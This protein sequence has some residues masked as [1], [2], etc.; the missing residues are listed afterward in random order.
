MS[1]AVLGL[2]VGGVS[3]T[4]AEC[5]DKSFPGFWDAIS[6][7]MRMRRVV[8]FGYRG[9]GK[10]PPGRHLLARGLNVP[11]L[12]TDALIEEKSGRTIPDIFR[13]D[14]EERFRE[15]ER[16]VIGA[17]PLHDV[18]VGTGG[19]AV[20][21]PEN[22]ERLRRDSVC[23]LLA[24]DLATIRARLAK[25]PRPP[26]TSLPP[27]EEIAQVMSRRCRQY[28]AS[29]D[30]CVDTS[31]TSNREAAGP[32]L[33][34]SR[35]RHRPCPGAGGGIP[36]VCGRPSRASELQGWNPCLPAPVLMCR[37]VPRHRRLPL[38]P[39]QKPPAL[40]PAFRAVPLELPLHAV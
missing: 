9:T 4:G 20:T 11:F 8:L 2:G 15:L 14:G 22:M 40:Q 36:V 28:A 17:L 7:V 30:F 16:D 10:T 21:D 26:L 13:N 39:Q 25:S 35:K 24:A 12:D 29:A 6:G 33:F 23:V 5:V 19:G 34:P 38:H 18:V 1:F 3:I 32:D 31:R 27:D 37:P